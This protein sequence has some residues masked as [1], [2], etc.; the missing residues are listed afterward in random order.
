M[1]KQKLEKI[2]ESLVAST[3][4]SNGISLSELNECYVV[5]GVQF[6]VP[7]I[8]LEAKDIYDFK[9]LLKRKLKKIEIEVAASPKGNFTSE[10]D[11]FDAYMNGDM[12]FGIYFVIPRKHSVQKYK[13]LKE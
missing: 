6:C 13:E 7:V 8:G 11:A 10:E 2:Y 1:D 5:D 3:K 12:E 4:D 9:M